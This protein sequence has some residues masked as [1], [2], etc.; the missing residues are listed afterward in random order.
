MVDLLIIMLERVSIIVAMAFVLTRFRFFKMMTQHHKLSRKQ[1][2]S[3]IILF[4]LF[5]IIGTY[6]GVS[7]NTSTTHFESVSNNLAQEE[8]IANSRVIGVVVAGLLGGS[9]LGIG[10]GLIAGVHRLMLGGFTAVACSV[11]T[12]ISGG[13]ASR[14]HRK[15]KRISTPIAFLVGALAEAFQMSL[16][17]LISKPF[18]QAWAL[19]SVIGLPMIIA[20]GIGTALFM[21]IIYSVSD[22]EE[23]ASAMQAEKTLRIANQT[24]GYLRQGMTPHTAE[25]V[26]HILY[27][28]LNPVAVAITDESRILAHVGIASDHH[29][30]LSEIQTHLTREVLQQGE[31]VV[32]DG[33]RI[34]CQ[35]PDCPLQAAVITPLK[36][37]GEAVG[38]LKLYY[39]SKK[40]INEV[41]IQMIRG[42]ASLLNDQLEL[43][44]AERLHQ[45]AKEAEIQ[46]LQAQISPHF[47]FNSMNVIISLIRTRPDEARSLLTSL[48]YFLRQN[49]ERTK[50]PFITI[51]EELAH[52]QAYVA[53]EE[54]RFVDQL[55]VI[56]QIDEAALETKI[57]PL[58]IQPLVENAIRY[59][60]QGCEGHCYVTIGIDRINDKVKVAVSDNG[61]GMTEEKLQKV[62]QQKDKETES[63]GVGLYNVNR[64]LMMTYGPTAA[65]QFQSELDIG[66]K[67][68]FV[69]DA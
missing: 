59:G 51:R 15:N 33:P 9:R 14:L 35:R 24:I 69:I 20:N 31:L 44:D 65:L 46:A 52:V 5:G 50:A 54:A 3:A 29:Q 37:R 19:V 36:L 57:P 66:T 4:G 16:I 7:F 8:A 25:Q 18:D 56:Q 58:S 55:T 68:Q 41:T 6:F 63:T 28:E 45:L 26:C 49:V 42:L 34:H 22:E 48:S 21:L 38:T 40:E 61:L 47:L 60:M 53:I 43:A 30:P 11:S 17:L 62:G 13:V 10:A 39:P 2:V 32:A 23:K 12:V 64:R 1:N 27:K 67:V